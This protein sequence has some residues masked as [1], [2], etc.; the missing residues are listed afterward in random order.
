MDPIEKADLLGAQTVCHNININT[1]VT[2]E[3]HITLYNHFDVHTD[4]G[5]A[6]SFDG[7]SGGGGFGDGGGGGGGDGGGD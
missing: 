5:D 3:T 7:W 1:S 2:I 4:S 6:V